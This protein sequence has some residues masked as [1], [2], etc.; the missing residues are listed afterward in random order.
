MTSTK[1][2]YEYKPCTCA[3]HSEDHH[4]VDKYTVIPWHLFLA[5]M[6]EFSH[7][8]DVYISPKDQ[9]KD[10]LGLSSSPLKKDENE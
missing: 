2:K 8:E 4:H 5:S 10:L 3:V 9:P 1:T 6:R 7:R